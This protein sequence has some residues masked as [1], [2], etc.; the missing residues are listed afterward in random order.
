MSRLFRQLQHLLPRARAWSITAATQL[1]QL[2]EGISDGL[3]TPA[4]ATVD[5]VWAQLQPS[6]TDEID[7]HEVE[8]GSWGVGSTAERR[9]RLALDW[10]ASEGPSPRA[11]QDFLQDA[12]FPLYYHG[13]WSGSAVRDPNSYTNTA[14]I[15]EW[16]C[17]DTEAECY[18]ATDA[19][20][21]ECDRFLVNSVNYIVN[22][23]LD[24]FAPPPIPTDS[25]KWRHF[26]YFGG[27][28]FPNTVAIDPDDLL[29]LKRILKKHCPAHLWIVL[30]AEAP[31]VF[32][33][34]FDASFE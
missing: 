27:E 18:T 11:L 3:L 19:I 9:A 14:L 32:D 5:G 33:A 34:T 25:D 1:R 10:A 28:T 2:F 13:W 26:I 12:G 6:T 15:G 16:Q 21:P 24:H 20:T 7:E 29:E 30:L 17:G 23:K 8:F 4:R 31:E 22:E